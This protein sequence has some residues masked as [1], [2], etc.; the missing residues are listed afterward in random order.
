MM[1]THT[2]YM[3]M[4]VTLKERN[5]RRTQ[6]IIDIIVNQVM[7]KNGKEKGRKGNL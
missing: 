2:H 3:A 4:N 1:L 5:V 6:D 7:K